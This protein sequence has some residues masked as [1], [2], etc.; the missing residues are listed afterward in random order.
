M[1]AAPFWSWFVWVIIVFYV[2]FYLFGR[3]YSAD[4]LKMMMGMS[5]VIIVYTVIMMS[6]IDVMSRVA[7]MFLLGMLYAYGC[8]SGF[9][10]KS[11]H[12]EM[13]IILPLLMVP[14]YFVFFKFQVLPP[15]LS[16]P[17]T[18]FVLSLIFIAA[19][20]KDV[21]KA[22]VSAI[23]FCIVMGA[24]V[25]TACSDHSTHNLMLIVGTALFGIIFET[26]LTRA[27]ESLGNNSY[28]M[29]LVQGAGL[30][31]AAKWF[32][33]DHIL[34]MLAAISVTMLATIP[35]IG[36]FERTKTI[37][38]WFDRRVENPKGGS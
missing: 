24:M 36:M 38:A 11:R 30:A 34:A 6:I 3:R 14:A 1:V 4:P 29:Y 26:P 18:V 8:N 15:A 25:F 21:W 27:F 13:F 7:P 23:L 12:N 19:N 35:L 28:E 37:V 10:M 31:A 2:A 33:T 20:K 22:S 16:I 5:A 32:G 9:R 17:G